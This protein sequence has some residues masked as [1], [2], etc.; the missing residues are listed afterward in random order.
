MNMKK[1]YTVLVSVFAAAVLFTS[2]NPK[3]FGDI[4]LSPN[5]P[6][7][8]YTTYLFTN[9][10]RYLYH[11]VTG[12][13]TNAYDPW[14]QEWN[15]YIAEIKNNQYGPLGTT[16]SYS[17]NNTFYLYPLK[18][19]HYIIEMNEDPEQVDLP[20]VAALG[21]PA[22]Q[23]AAAKTLMGF[24]YM[25]MSD[26]V[27][28][29]VVSEAFKGASED[30]WYPK[31]DT[32]KEVYE[33]I[34]KSLSEAY[35][36][37]DASGSLNAAADANFGGD[38][39][40][41]KKFNASVRMLAAIKLSD[42]DEAT[43]KARFAKAYSDGGMTDVADGLFHTHD[44]LN[45]NMMYYWCNP[46]YDGA[47]FGMAPNKYIVDQMK[48]FEDNRMFKYF[49][50]EG[51]K[52]PRSEELFPRDQY[53]SFYGV[54][55]GLESNTAVNDWTGCCASIA[56]SMIAMDA[57][58]PVITA[59]RV[60]LVEAEAAYRGWISAD[61]KALYEAGIK[62]SFEQ[63]SATGAD[64]Y[65]ASD[66]VAYDAANGLEQIAI[67]RW[68][69]GYLADGIE[70]W[71]DWRRLDIPKL[72]VGPE[73]AKQGN[74][75]FPYRLAFYNGHDRTLN[76]EQYE[77]ALKDLSGGVDDVNNRVWWDVADNT[78][79]VIPAEECVPPIK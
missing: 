18:N 23:I 58:L 5:S 39:A 44:D 68:I 49:D 60:L 63:W 25:T 7:T 17:S 2:C 15:G 32:Q 20:N 35:A 41:W 79:G 14:Q 76:T 57:S 43:G 29:L 24:Y 50:I 10:Q 52:G 54:P 51:Y 67:Q 12:N 16:T 65:I 31:Y 27:G 11:F 22:N 64:E 37:F 1:I 21:T 26:I 3:D 55:F 36:Q 40:K 62:S 46:S 48:E 73:A 78:E 4:N 47:G 9:A 56:S 42:V 34:D 8:A 69:A 71:S 33:F 74:T 19:L 28:P 77:L 6:S 75:H 66:K 72:F 38:I 45:W 30:N 59:A 13:A 53:T 70:A 61:A